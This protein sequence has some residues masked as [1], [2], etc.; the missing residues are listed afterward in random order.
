MRI[1]RKSS[2]IRVLSRYYIQYVNC[3]ALTGSLANDRGGSTLHKDTSSKYGL[4]ELTQ[5]KKLPTCLECHQ[6]TLLPIF[7]GCPKDLTDE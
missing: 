2:T 7:Q 3:V 6:R 1:P 4:T 5:D